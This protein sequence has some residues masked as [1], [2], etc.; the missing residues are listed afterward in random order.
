MDFHTNPFY[1]R[2]S[3]TNSTLFQPRNKL[4]RII[5][6]RPPSIKQIP[7]RMI[8]RNEI[9]GMA[10]MKIDTRLPPHHRV[11]AHLFSSL[12]S[13]LF[14]L[15]FHQP[16]N[17]KWIFYRKA[18]EKMPSMDITIDI[19]WKELSN[20]GYHTTAKTIVIVTEC[21]VWVSCTHSKSILAR[22]CCLSVHVM[23]HHPLSLP[24]TFHLHPPPDPSYPSTPRHWETKASPEK[25]PFIMYIR[26]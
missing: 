4:Q 6:A 12:F 15:Y 11:I 13:S 2:K 26:L 16:A 21:P 24:R 3:D 25:Y 20:N 22:A 5:I 8:R 7:R 17:T 18:V 10:M 19:A 1:Y 9:H 14:F 23:Q